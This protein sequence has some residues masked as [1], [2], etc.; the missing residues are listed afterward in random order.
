MTVH[1]ARRIRRQRQLQK[2]HAVSLPFYS[3]LFFFLMCVCVRAV[4]DV[5]QCK[6][7]LELFLPLAFPI[8]QSFSAQL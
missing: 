7:A 5:K 8:D 3:G 1:P 6:L 4:C 2:Q